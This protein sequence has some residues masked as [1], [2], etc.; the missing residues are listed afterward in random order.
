MRI[1]RLIILLLLSSLT[2]HAQ[3]WQYLDSLGKVLTKQQEFEKADS[4]FKIAIRKVEAQHGKDTSY[5]KVALRLGY[6]Q[7]YSGEYE[8]A[9][10]L[11]LE[12]MLIFEKFYGKTHLLYAGCCLNLGVVYHDM[13][14]HNNAEKF[15]GEA[16]RIRKD[17]LGSEHNDYAA[18]C[19]NLGNLYTEQGLYKQAEP[20]FREVQKIKEK[21]FGSESIEYG[22]FCSNFAIFHYE[23][24]RYTE[25]EVLYL[26]AKS[27]IKK[28]LGQNHTEYAFCCSNLANLYQRMDKFQEAELLYKEAIHIRKDK[29]KSQDR[30]YADVCNNLGMLY[31]ELGLYEQAQV[32]IIE[33]KEIR[34]EIL[35]ESHLD[36]AQS[37]SNLAL[38]SMRLERYADA[39][40]LYEFARTIAK[41]SLDTENIEYLIISA[42]LADLYHKL[43]LNDKA[44]DIYK[45]VM[46][47]QEA[48]LGTEHPDYAYTCAAA[49]IVYSALGLHIEADRI[50]KMALT[51]IENLH[52]KMHI[53]YAQL[54]AMVAESQ[55]MMNAYST[56]HNINIDIIQNKTEQ[57]CALFPSF[58][59]QEKQAYW[60]SIRHFFSFS[61]LL[62]LRYA[63]QNPFMMA[64]LYDQTLFTKGIIFSSTQKMKSAILNSNDA[65]LIEQYNNWKKQRETYTKYYQL[66][67]EEQKRQKLNLDSIKNLVNDIEK[68]LSKKSALFGENVQ[69]KS[70]K[71]QDVQ[72][73][74]TKNDVVVEIIKSD[75][76]YIVLFITTQTEDYPSYLLFE[77]HAELEDKFLKYYK[78]CI[79]FKVEDTVSF[80]AFWKP[81]ADK[82]L[83]LQKK[84]FKKIYLSPDGVFHQISLNTLKNPKTGKF[85]LEES[86]IQLIGSSRDLIELSKKSRNLSQ[87]YENYQAHLVGYPIYGAENLEKEAEK[88]RDRS[89]GF[90]GMQSAVGVAGSVSLLP[91][92]KKEVE[93]L[94]GLFNQKKLK[95]NL[96]LAENATEAAIKNL[97]S[98]TILHVATHGFFIPEV[99]ENSVKDMESA[100][101][102][103]LLR[104]PFM[105]SGLL[106]AGCQ[107][108]NPNTEDGILTAEEAMN[109]TLDNT[110][111]VVMSACETGLGDIKAGEGV[112]GLQR[113]FQQA[114]AKSVLMSLWK[115][116]DDATQTLMTEFYTALLKGQSKRQALKTAQLSL[117]KR[118]PEP[119]YWGA[120]VLVG[121]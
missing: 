63:A 90:S 53:D 101:N 8:N 58:S 43:N 94:F 106:L 84:G 99:K 9:E 74:L 98:P 97:K 66:P 107:K 36:Y 50:G 108:P 39:Q 61:A 41:G 112:F 38:I 64:S 48:M 23:Q 109:L 57:I 16:R 69:T 11:L 27:T 102:R 81:I 89:L 34:K 10:R 78:N 51:T 110:E 83:T 3:T 7:S 37:C 100:M 111:L 46:T 1:C 47:A 24:A 20:L 119:Y 70:Y 22:I 65:V 117:K 45:E 85:L 82:L 40:K 96:L 76:A 105:R 91:G 116:D 73:K 55:T 87:N 103:N 31:M 4:V 12:A 15:Y 62:T 104:N 86:E 26:K 75:S 35:G 121:E 32:L 52:G 68:E 2:A 67:A 33:A 28:L 49:S 120:F 72:A 30:Y 80:N 19:E 29:L 113:A 56:A 13:G 21:V 14:D 95:V 115:V 54:A 44:L 59:E 114:G 6:I 5:A 77:N 17:I 60:L 93:N 18:V 92:T 79:E 118:F 25:A 42:N 88:K 71:W